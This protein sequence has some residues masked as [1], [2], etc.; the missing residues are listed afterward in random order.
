LFSD[1]FLGI[2]TVIVLF[3]V[4]LCYSHSLTVVGHPSA[5][6]IS[7]LSDGGDHLFAG[8]G[9][10][11]AIMLHRAFEIGG[12]HAMRHRGTLAR[13]NVARVM[14]ICVIVVAAHVDSAAGVVS[15]NHA[16]A[17]VLP[18]L[19]VGNLLFYCTFTVGGVVVAGIASLHTAVIVVGAVMVITDYT[20]TIHS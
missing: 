20:R 11:G 9:V 19:P 8:D 2:G 4:K 10:V 14:H 7:R 17:L 1:H 6:Q 16:A 13:S 18:F 5:E 3:A 12:H 15:V